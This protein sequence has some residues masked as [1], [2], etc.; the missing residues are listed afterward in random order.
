MGNKDNA[1]PK[2]FSSADP[3]SLPVF[4]Q[5][6]RFQCKIYMWLKNL[7]YLKLKT[8]A[9]KKVFSNFINVRGGIYYKL[10]YYYFFNA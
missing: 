5:A 10:F 6:E 1:I 8:V 3:T 4:P 2:V 9:F 7:Q